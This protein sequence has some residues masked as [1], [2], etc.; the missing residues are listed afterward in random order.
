MSTVGEASSE[1]VRRIAG[2]MR[3]GRLWRSV[4]RIPSIVLRWLALCTFAYVFLFPVIFMFTMSI[5]TVT[6]LNDPSIRWI[7]RSPTLEGYRTAL[8]VLEYLDSLRISAFTSV[9]AALGQTLVGAM[10]AYSAARLRFPGRNLLFGI[11][12]F[13]VIVPVQTIMVP[14]FMLYTRLKVINTYW[15]LIVPPFLGYGVRGGI[16]LIVY[17]QFFRGLPYELEDAA[18]VDGAGALRTFWQIMLPLAKPAI[19][20]VLVFSLVWTWNDTYLPRMIINE[21]PLY[22]LP[23]RMQEFAEILNAR[24]PAQ[25]S[26]TRL[27]EN[28]FMAGVVLTVLPMLAMY[29]FAQRYFTQSIDRTGLVE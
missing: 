4:G 11:L 9:V 1:Y 3:L 20:V 29:I 26:S 22:T 18:Y 10:V 12:L 6:E 21:R 5:K 14:Q 2:R 16:L 13:T 23:Q 25:R 17:R 24:I 28:T 19:L 27:D 8:T 7:S 15:P